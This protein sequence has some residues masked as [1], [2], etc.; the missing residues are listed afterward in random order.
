M[1]IATLG[2][3]LLRA[4]PQAI[5]AQKAS[6]NQKLAMPLSDTA[7][8]A[9]MPIPI[10]ATLQWYTLAHRLPYQLFVLRSRASTYAWRWQA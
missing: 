3:I 8:P 1:L 2:A 5:S 7:A 10:G 9:P 4:L 6:T